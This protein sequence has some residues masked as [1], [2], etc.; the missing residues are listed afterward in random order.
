MSGSTPQ[1]TE[2]DPDTHNQT[3]MEFGDSY[4]RTGRIEAPEEERNSTG[5][6]TNLDLWKL[7][8]TEPPTKEHTW[9][10]IRLQHI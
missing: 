6:T 1:L 10:R 2:T 3:L 7:S 5:R 4:G 9:A 8:E